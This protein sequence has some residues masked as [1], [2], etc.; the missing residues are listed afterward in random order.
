MKTKEQAAQEHAKCTVENCNWC[1]RDNPRDTDCSGIG[2]DKYNGFL[3]GF[4]FANQWIS[5]KDGFPP[6]NEAVLIK[7]DGYIYFGCYDGEW[8]I[9]SSNIPDE[10]KVIAWRPIYNQ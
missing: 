4:D 1:G 7:T 5:T 9:D 2:S 8:H 6:Y 10:F 3:A